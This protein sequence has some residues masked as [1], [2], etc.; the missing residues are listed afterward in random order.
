MNREDLIDRVLRERQADEV[1]SSFGAVVSADQ[2]KGSR[3][4]E[5]SGDWNMAIGQPDDG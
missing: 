3:T 4:A 2:E 1:G 5:E